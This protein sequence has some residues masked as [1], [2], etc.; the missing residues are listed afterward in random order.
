MYRHTNP[1]KHLEFIFLVP[2]TKNSIKT[3]RR[4]LA[5]QSAKLL[6]IVGLEILGAI[7]MTRK[8]NKLFLNYNQKVQKFNY[9]V[10]HNIIE[11]K[12]IDKP[13]I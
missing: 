9:W 5:L 1:I 11:S 12:N 8:H 7:Q 6:E 3:G 10:F 4:G 2:S 13:D